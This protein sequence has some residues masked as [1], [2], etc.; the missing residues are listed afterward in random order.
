VVF[1]QRTYL[2]VNVR[3]KIKGARMDHRYS[4]S[5]ELDALRL[6]VDELSSQPITWFNVFN[7]VTRHLLTPFCYGRF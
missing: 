5:A 4:V 7:R 3:R 1:D 2:A 6:E